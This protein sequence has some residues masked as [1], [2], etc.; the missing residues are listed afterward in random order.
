M[1][2]KRTIDLLNQQDSDHRPEGFGLGGNCVW[3]VL[4]L[5]GAHG[6]VKCTANQSEGEKNERIEELS[7]GR[8]SR[9]DYR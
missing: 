7:N 4:E 3:Q 9:Q 6:N 8:D 1:Q 2:L 5:A